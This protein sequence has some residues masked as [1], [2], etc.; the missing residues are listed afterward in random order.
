MA[1]QPKSKRQCQELW[2]TLN[3]D[4]KKLLRYHPPTLT[5]IADLIDLLQLG[6]SCVV[7]FKGNLLGESDSIPETSKETPLVLL[8]TVGKFCSSVRQFMHAL[9]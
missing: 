2:Y 7:K 4:L 1:G 5:D 8:T 9:P 6:T 3:T